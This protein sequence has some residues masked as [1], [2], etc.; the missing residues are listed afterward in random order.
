[1]TNSI[2]LNYLWFWFCLSC[3][4]LLTQVNCRQPWILISVRTHSTAAYLSSPEHFAG[5]QNIPIF[6]WRLHTLAVLKVSSN[7]WEEPPTNGR[8]ERKEGEGVIYL[9]KSLPSE[10]KT[11]TQREDVMQFV[12]HRV[13]KGQWNSHCSLSHHPE[14]TL[15]AR[16]PFCSTFST[17]IVLLR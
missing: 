10:T 9:L 8:A 2:P 1:M 16:N 7:S 3:K 15:Q 11:Q 17:A 14:I 12:M 5:T 4:P 13:F 6:H